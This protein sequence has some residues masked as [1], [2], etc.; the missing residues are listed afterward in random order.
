MMMIQILLHWEKF[1]LRSSE[2][3]AV[4]HVNKQA[5]NCRAFILKSASFII[6]SLILMLVY[7][8][9]LFL[10]SGAIWWPTW[11]ITWSEWSESWLLPHYSSQSF[12]LLFHIVLFKMLLENSHLN[13]FTAY[14]FPWISFCPQFIRKKVFL[15]YSL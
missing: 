8:T 12:K 5:N 4:L 2:S 1:F 9:R 6:F 15:L 10:A 7:T 11:V 3:R 13:C 14:F